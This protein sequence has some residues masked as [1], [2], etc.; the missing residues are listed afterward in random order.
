[1]VKVGKNI[2]QELIENGFFNDWRA[3]NEILKKLSQRGFTISGRK[4]GNVGQTL[5]RMCRDR[6]TGLERDEVAVSQIKEAG[7]KWKYKKV[8]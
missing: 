3:M 5:T 7:G 8:R 4:A 2:I 1:M 6:S